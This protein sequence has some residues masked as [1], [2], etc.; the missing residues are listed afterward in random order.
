MKTYRTKIIVIILE[1]ILLIGILA[2]IS[3]SRSHSKALPF[4]ISQQLREAFESELVIMAEDNYWLFV[5]QRF[6][7]VND[8]EG[9][10]QWVKIDNAYGRNDYNFENTIVEDGYFKYYMEN[11]EVNSSVGIDVSKYQGAID[12]AQVKAS[13]VDFAFVRVGYRGYG[14]GKIV[15]D[16][17]FDYNVAEALKNDLNV[18][19]YFFSQAMT[20]EEG[21]EEAQFVLNNVKAYNI[22]LP[23]VLDTEDAMDEDARTANLTPE[24]RTQACIGFMDTIRAAGY[25]TMLYANLRWIALDLDISQLHGYDIWFA[26]YA[27]EPQLPYNFK[28]WQY[29][30]EGTVPGISQP[31]DLNIGF[32]FYGKD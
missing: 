29:S 18:G 20:Y 26:Q 23:I 30:Q 11:D 17:T 19:V 10:L 8:D 15:L 24:E 31:V 13:G 27:S 1:A 3:L 21:V 4:E 9:V 22:N 14:N 16:D 6:I 25:E 32:D 2:G 12:W 5:N 28:I 7:L